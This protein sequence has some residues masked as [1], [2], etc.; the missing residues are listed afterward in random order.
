MYETSAST[1]MEVSEISAA[2]SIQFELRIISL[3]LRFVE[4]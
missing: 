2:Y 3:K 4:L 1:W